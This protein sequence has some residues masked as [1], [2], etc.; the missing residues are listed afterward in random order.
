MSPVTAKHLQQAANFALTTSAALETKLLI[1]LQPGPKSVA[2]L[3]ADGGLDFRATEIVLSLLAQLGFVSA[4]GDWYEL[5]DEGRCQLVDQ[6]ASEYAADGFPLWLENVR[7]W[8]SLPDVL[9]TGSPVPT[10]SLAGVD[11]SLEAFSA[12]MISQS[13][14][15]VASVVARC[16]ELLPAV[17]TALDLGG[18]P[19][20]YARAFAEVGVEVTLLDIPAMVDHAC[21]VYSLG[22]VPGIRLVK[23]DFLLDPLPAGPFDLVLLMNV[24]HLYPPSENC[25]LL[26]RIGQVV[27]PGGLLAIGDFVRGR[28][29]IAPLKAAIMLLRTKG[30]NTYTE[31]EYRRWLAEAGFSEVQIADVISADRQLITAMRR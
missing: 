20:H 11:E 28:S 17:R 26:A 27:S 13:A 15:R 9:R 6:T 2:Q 12:G 10:D 31:L 8:L 19:G 30:G 22:A 14:P 16:Q 24:C 3:A 1:Q 18:G 25:A 5:T 21:R 23:G 4:R 29:P 7:R